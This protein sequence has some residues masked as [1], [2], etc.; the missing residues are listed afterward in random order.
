MKNG[1][2]RA[3][4]FLSIFIGNFAL[5]GDQISLHEIA[6]LKKYPKLAKRD[7]KGLKI[8]QSGKFYKMENCKFENDDDQCAF[9]Y[10][11]N[12]ISLYDTKTKT[13]RQIPVIFNIGYE[14]NDYEL[15]A[16]A[17]DFQFD[18]APFAS[19]DGKNIASGES[20][21]NE[22][23]AAGN[24]IITNAMNKDNFYPFDISCE[25]IVWK[26]NS[27]LE[28]KCSINDDTGEPTFFSANVLSDKKSVWK[29]V[30]QNPK[31]KIQKTYLPQNAIVMH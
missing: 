5:A 13:K 27:N 10:F 12:V 18:S 22:M 6:L 30:A 16:N 23:T 3:L 1:K 15:R 17:M 24:L 9:H 28:V 26:S 31:G 14:W 20:R 8:I 11:N 29:L 7:A 25:P 4:A 21:M 2:L 19:P